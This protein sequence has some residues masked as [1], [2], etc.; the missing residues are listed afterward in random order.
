[1]PVR[2][3]KRGA[4]RTPL[5]GD[6]DVIVCGASFGGLA[7]ARGSRARPRACRPRS[8]R[9]R[10]APDLGLRHPHPMAGH[11]RA[12][13]RAAADVPQI[14]VHTPTGPRAGSCRGRSRPSTTGSCAACCG[15]SPATP[16]SRRPRSRAATATSSTPTAAICA[17][18]S[19]SMGWAG[20]GC[21][22]RGPTCSRPR[23]SCPGASRSTRTARRRARAV[24]RPLATC[25]PATAGRSRRTTSCASAWLV[26]PPLP[27]QGPDPAPGRRP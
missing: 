17:H 21:C 13:R 19:S 6:W 4:E 24:A 11:A 14:V 12:A 15:S 7:V 3:T 18:R 20:A 5:T 8:L 9:D 10:R 23:R 27:R 26:R 1:M 22:P 25:P 16:C 2:A